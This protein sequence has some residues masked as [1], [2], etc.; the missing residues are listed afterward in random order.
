[1]NDEE[2]RT[3]AAEEKGDATGGV[4]P[5]KNWP[6]L[7]AYYLGLFAVIPMLG[8]LL[9]IAAFILGIAGLRKRKQHP[10]V[11]GAV[12]AWIGI[13]CGAFFAALWI[14][15]LVGMIASHG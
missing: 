3:A 6:A 8:I 9:G 13:I 4:I 15:L 10:A 14:L 12:H 7:V 2:G 11:K 1:M 5:H